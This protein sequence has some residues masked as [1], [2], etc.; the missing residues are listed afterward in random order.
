[1]SHLWNYVQKLGMLDSLIWQPEALRKLNDEELAVCITE[2]L[3]GLFWARKTKMRTVPT[4][5]PE[6]VLSY[7]SKK[8]GKQYRSLYRFLVKKP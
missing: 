5:V 1:M 8:E 4:P 6:E 7:I 2:E 3:R